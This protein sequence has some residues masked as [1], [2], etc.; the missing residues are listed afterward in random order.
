[1]SCSVIKPLHCP[2][3][4]QWFP[5]KGPQRTCLILHIVR[6]Q[7]KIGSYTRLICSSYSVRHT[8]SEAHTAIGCQALGFKAVRRSLAP[9]LP[10]LLKLIPSSQS[11]TA[12]D[13]SFSLTVCRKVAR[14]WEKIVLSLVDNSS[15]IIYPIIII[16]RKVRE[17]QTTTSISAN[18]SL[19]RFRG[20]RK[21]EES[22]CDVRI[23]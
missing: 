21:T 3:Q 19:T 10:S 12:F 23:P 13:F 17:V 9:C 18:T 16:F 8:L 2:K 1:M 14:F 20:L 4:F 11:R 7:R 22:C 5:K 15:S 6:T